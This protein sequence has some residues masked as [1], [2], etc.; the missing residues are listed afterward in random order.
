MSTTNPAAEPAVQR[1]DIA[2]R[3]PNLLGRGMDLYF[4]VNG[5]HGHIL[6]RPT[7]KFRSEPAALH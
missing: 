5:G 7:D 4:F 1:T 6:Q 3:V 2:Q